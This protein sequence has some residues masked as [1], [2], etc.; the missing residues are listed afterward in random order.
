[1]ARLPSFRRWLPRYRL[2]TLLVFVSLLCAVLAREANY[3]RR[4]N[5]ACAEFT[6]LG[7][8]YAVQRHWPKWA[9]DATGKTFRYV[10]VIDARA[11]SYP[12][13]RYDEPLEDTIGIDP[14]DD[15]SDIELYFILY[16]PRSH[17]PTDYP[18]RPEEV[19]PVIADCRDCRVLFLND[20]A[21]TDAELVHLEELSR[22][23]TLY[24]QNTTITDAG[25]VHLRSLTRLIDLRVSGTQVTRA[26]AAE[27][28][29]AIPGLWI[30][31]LN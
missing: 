25:L 16:N 26:G 22:L 8:G 21:V 17:V 31:I 18:F 28:A 10:H 9:F 13:M 14:K 11:K 4:Q 7:V 27:L 12:G 30:D 1:M 5:R 24:L 2:T 29:A 6:R 19:M 23:R 15:L 20:L 3:Y